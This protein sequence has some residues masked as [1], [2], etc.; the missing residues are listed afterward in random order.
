V[1]RQIATVKPY[2]MNN[3][4]ILSFDSKWIEVCNGIPTFTVVIDKDGRL[5]LIG[6]VVS[7]KSRGSQQ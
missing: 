4:L 2:L 6:P 1:T 7:K 5:G 3:Y